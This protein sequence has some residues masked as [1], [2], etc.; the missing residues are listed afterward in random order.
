MDEILKCLAVF[1]LSMLKFFAGPL[2]GIQSGLSF[3]ETS[4]FTSLG[5]MAS[6]FLFTTI[7]GDKFHAWIVKTFNKKNPKLFTKKNRRKVRIWR[8]YGLKGV[9]FLT[10]IIFSPIGGTIVATSFGESRKRI[11][12]Y[13]FLSSVFWSVTF[14]LVLLLIKENSISLRF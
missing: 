2:C 9:A 7:L 13:M 8:S 10:P 6:V 3:L 4:I 14:S 5:M 11:Y 1:G 12:F